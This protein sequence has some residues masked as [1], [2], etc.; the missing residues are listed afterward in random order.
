VTSPEASR[1]VPLIGTTK[2]LQA[3]HRGWSL[4][5]QGTGGLERFTGL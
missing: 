4:C 3:L 5:T 2:G 1:I